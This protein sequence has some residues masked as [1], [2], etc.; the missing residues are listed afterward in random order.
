VFIREAALEV[1][2]ESEGARCNVPGAVFPLGAQ[3]VVDGAAIDGV[4]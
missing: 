4:G 1:R 2:L 3:K